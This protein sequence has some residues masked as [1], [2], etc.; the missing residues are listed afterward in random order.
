[1][2]EAIKSLIIRTITVIVICVALHVMVNT[3]FDSVGPAVT[4]EIAL[5]QMNDTDKAHIEMR[6]YSNTTN[7]LR[8]YGPPVAYGAIAIIL[9]FAPVNKLINEGKET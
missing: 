9:L 7:N 3:Y 2:N 1:M 6:M 5:N 8:T 4:D